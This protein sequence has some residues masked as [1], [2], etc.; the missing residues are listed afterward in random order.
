MPSLT[1]TIGSFD[2]V[3]LGHLHLLRQL[4]AI[5]A[6]RDSVPA[7]V[8]FTN[9]PL[10]V[11]NPDKAPALLSTPDEKRDLLMKAGAGIV[12]LKP[13]TQEMRRMSAE[14]FLKLLHE[15]YAVDTL[16]LGFNNRFGNDP[17]LTFAD[18]QRLGKEIGIEVIQA[19][20]V[21]AGNSAVSSTVIRNL[22]LEGRPQQATE[23]LGRPYSL[24]GNVVHGKQLGRQLGYPTANILPESPSKL[25]P[26]RGVY[27]CTAILPGGKSYPAM[28]N[29]GER[30]TLDE[31]HPDTTIE[32]HIIGVNRK[33]YGS[34]VTLL[35]H[36]FLR[37][38]K[39]F[40]SLDRLKTQLQADKLQVIK[41]LGFTNDATK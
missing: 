11:I 16:L 41:L 8:T 24:T 30:P 37:P 9:H 26:A 28:V 35:F 14:R 20:E 22:L 25:I 15:R 1:A 38:E 21:R 39:K 18:Y 7:V 10:Q 6:E 32:A 33:L 36:H 12:V 2:G 27:A 4:T 17:S 29:I 5:A 34:T 19:D 3:H 40:S 13:F 23:L 31:T